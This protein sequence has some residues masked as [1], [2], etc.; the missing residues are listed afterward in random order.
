MV[1]ATLPLTKFKILK[2]KRGKIPP[3]P[4]H[5]D[6]IMEVRIQTIRRIQLSI[7]I[8]AFEWNKLLTIWPILNLIIGE[9]STAII[10]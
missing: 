8:D 7:F 2:R 3:M 6:L 9:K 5:N 4:S 1:P 10:Y